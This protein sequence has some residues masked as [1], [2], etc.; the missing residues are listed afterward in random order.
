ME[1]SGENWPSYS[2]LDVGDYVNDLCFDDEEIE[3]DETIDPM[4]LLGETKKKRRERKLNEKLLA[5]SATIPGLKKKMDN[6]SILDKASNYVKELQ[7]HV[8]ELEQEVGSQSCKNNET[9]SCI[10]VNSDYYGEP[11]NHDNI[12]LPEVRV[13]VLH[14]E[15]LII[16]HCEKQK[17]IMLQILS[18][19]ENLHLSMVHNSVLPFGKST[20]EITIIA[21]M[22]D[23]YNMTTDELVKSLRLLIMTQ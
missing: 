2:D 1:E 13:R 22:G 8:R 18:H 7:E 12:I 11:N 19:L 6:T 16:I 17:S 5:L 14:K 10:E 23:E 4:I 21:Q 3:S 9:S 15:V 20:L